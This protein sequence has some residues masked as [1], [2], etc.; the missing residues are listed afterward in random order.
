[1]SIT[2]T[3]H[4]LT[5]AQLTRLSQICNRKPNHCGVALISLEN[6]GLVVELSEPQ[7]FV[8]SRWP[9]QRTHRPTDAG[10]TALEQARAAG[11]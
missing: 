8:T 1:M 5:D 9:N 2:Y 11:W 3:E 10:R 7:V 4:K 6:K